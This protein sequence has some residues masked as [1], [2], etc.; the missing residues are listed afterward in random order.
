MRF[1]K[2]HPTSAALAAVVALGCSAALAPGAEGPVDVRSSGAVPT[3]LAPAPPP[4]EPSALPAPP[5]AVAWSYRAGA[6]LAA[7]P[8]IG[9]D[10]AV[11]L[12]SVDGYLHSLRADGSF[13]WGYTLR[14]PIVGRPA[15]APN[16]SVF[17]AAKPNG[18]YAL[19]SEG[20]LLW[21]SSVIGGVQSPAVVDSERRV[22]VTTGQGTL[23]GFSNRGGI[24][25]FAKA[26]TAQL[27]GPAPLA[28]GGVVIASMNGD[29]KI[30]GQRGAPR[31]SAPGPVFGLETANDS[32]FVL[33]AE[34]LARIDL[35]AGEERWSRSDV[36]RV[37]C[38]SPA[39]VVV[40]GRGLR[41][42][43]PQGEPQAHVPVALGTQRPVACLSDGSL[44]LIDDSGALLRVDTTGVRARGK[45]PAGRLVS[46]D[47]A[48]G[49]LVIA[50]YRDGRVLAFRPPTPR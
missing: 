37:A 21:V 5:V 11:T 29:V 39:L 9:S 32:L 44:L 50:G 1:R 4:V 36:A 10:G 13:R 2:P 23:L 43:S 20:T 28:D 49:E 12:G 22:W 3:F 15:I 24:V 40:E 33:G 47:P 18:L 25:G 45:L 41:W 26:G 31:A 16:G 38:A 6:P 35:T 42:L 48:G 14:G 30:A 19:D 17:V 27:L 34:G 8:G 46:L 7:P